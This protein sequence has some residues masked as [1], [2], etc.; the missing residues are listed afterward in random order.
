MLISRMK[1]RMLF[2]KF[3]SIMFWINSI[4][5]W[6]CKNKLP[7]VKGRNIKPKKGGHEENENVFHEEGYCFLG[8]KNLKQPVDL[9]VYPYD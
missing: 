2:L 5:S 9:T 4:Y 6:N 7:L 8:R 3:I 1:N